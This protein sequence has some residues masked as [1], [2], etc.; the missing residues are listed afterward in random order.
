M[1]CVNLGSA[2]ATASTRDH[3]RLVQSAID[4]G[5]TVLDT[6]DAY[7]N[8]S[9]ERI[10]GRAIRGRRDS[11]TISTKGGY[12][13]RERAPLEQ[14]LR[15]VTGAALRRVGCERA[16]RSVSDG[17]GVRSTYQHQDF[18]PTHLRVALERS[19][20]RLQIDCVDVYQ[21]HGPRAAPDDVY[22]NL[23]GEL[24]ALREAGKVRRFGVGAE[25]VPM[26]ERWVT[27][28]GVDVV[29]LPFGVLDPE[30]AMS[31]LPAARERGVDVWAR[32]VL[33][34]G[35]LAAAIADPHSAARHDK[36]R[37]VEGLTR[38]AAES[39]IRLD[40][41]AI[42]WVAVHPGIATALLGMSSLDHLHRNLAIAML[43]PLPDDVATAIDAL[44]RQR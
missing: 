38:V 9:S 20:R 30:A 1:G 5:V 15:R 6:A 37:L 4:G 22:D 25:S 7:G 28:A 42:R 35:V 26:A 2:T 12:V 27:A 33:G 21:L 13:F 32:A 40:E 19:L 34:G 17:A 29:Q 14:S 8:G 44:V 43:P 18:S 31:V 10:V 24:E 39:S 16:T 23:F 3:I 41:L 11:V 36:A